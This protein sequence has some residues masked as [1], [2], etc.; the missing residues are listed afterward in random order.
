MD[1]GPGTW[2][3]GYLTAKP[4]ILASFYV[5]P[6]CGCEVRRRPNTEFHYSLPPP[7]SKISEAPGRARRQAKLPCV[8]EHGSGA[9]VRCVPGLPPAP[10]LAS[11]VV[12]NAECSRVQGGGLQSLAIPIMHR[13]SP[14]KRAALPGSWGNA[15]LKMELEALP[16]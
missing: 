12:Q 6:L 1:V 9:L 7:I 16:S 2:A 10:D 3:R 14:G 11:P 4:I 13:S 15:K 5:V 8:G